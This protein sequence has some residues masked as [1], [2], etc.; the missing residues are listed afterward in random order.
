MATPEEIK[1]IA[2]LYVAYF[3]RAPDPEGLEFWVNQLDNGRDFATISQD[4]ADSP[5]AKE[6]YPFLATPEVSGLDPT[7]LVT[8]IYNN[9]FG[10]DPEAQ[11]LN[12]W[13]DVVNSGAVAVGD[14]VEAI[15]LGAQDAVVE[16]ELVLDKTTVENRI[17]CALEYSTA[18][19]LIPG[20]EFDTAA[21]NVAR[22]VVDSVD[23]TQESVDA[24]KLVLAEYIAGEGTQSGATFTLCEHE[25]LVS[26]EVINEQ[27]VTETVIYWGFNPHSNGETD[28]DNTAEPNTN[29]LTNEGPSDGGI[30]A[31][32]FFND[33]FQ[34]IVAANFNEIDEIDVDEDTFSTIDFASLRDVTVTNGDAGT[35]TV[36]FH[37]SD[38]SADDI[39]LGNA[40]LDL[41]RDLIFDEE[42]NSRFFEQE[43]AAQVP[44]YVTLS[45]AVTLDGNIP[46]TTQIGTVDAV[47]TTVEGAVYATI[48]PI[49]T[50][51]V[52]NGGTFEPGF[53]DQDGQIDNLIVAG[54]LDLLH[55]AIIDGG[56]G[57]NTLE[58]DAKGHFAQPKSL[59]NIQQISIEN[60]PNI[61]TQNDAD[62]S[63][64][65]P[66]VQEGAIGDPDSVIDLTRAR[67]VE[68]VTIT[69]GSYDG[70]DVGNV[71]GEDESSQ[72]GDLSVI[73]LRND[74]TLTLQ[75]Q[76]QNGDVL[77][78]TSEG[79]TGD[80]FTVILDNV[81]AETNMYIAE[82]GTTLNLVS[83]GGGNH[84]D[85]LTDLNEGNL[86][87]LNISG[88]AHLFIENNLNAV[89]DD[90]TPATIDA[91]ANTGGVDLEI[92][93][94]EQLTFIGSAGDDRFAVGT[95]QGG[96]DL[97]IDY[98]GDME[99]TITNA[100][101][102]NY[103][104]IR[105][106]DV[107][108]TDG[109]GD[110]S[111]DSSNGVTAT[112]TAGDGDNTVQMDAGH[113][114]I[115]FGDGD[116]TLNLALVDA[117][118]LNPVG[119]DEVETGADI[120]LGDGANYVAI[121]VS[122][123]S[124]TNG[125][126]S[127]TSV[128]LDMPE[129]SI[130]AGDG[131]NTILIPGLP[132]DSGGALT[133][134]DITTGGGDDTILVAAAEANISTGGGDD[135][136]TL[137]GVDDDYVTEV[138]SVVSGGEDLS[139]YNFKGFIPSVYGIEFT[140]DTG[141][142]SATINLGAF[143]DNLAEVTGAMVAGEGSSITGNDIT[144]FV[145]TDAD[146]RAATL[147][148]I[149]AIVM[150]DDNRAFAGQGYGDTAGSASGAASLTLL[151]TQVAQLLAEG[152]DFSTQGETFGAKSVLTIVITGDVTLSDLID[153]AS[154]NDSVKLCFVVEDGASLTLTAQE[155]HTYVAP[156]GI[157]VDDQ[158]GFVDNQVIVTDAGPEFN[159]FDGTQNGGIG[160]G[161]IAGDGPMEDVLIL[162][163]EEGF[164]RPSQ[165]PGSSL[166]QWNSDEDDN[167]DVTVY[168]FATDLE[169]TGSAD[170]SVN[171]PIILGDAFT[172]DF[173]EFTGDF[174]QTVNG[175]PT[176]TV[177]NFQAITPDVN[178][179]D[180]DP[181]DGDTE[182]TGLPDPDTWG[183][184]AGNGTSADPVRINMLVEEGTSTGDCDLGVTEGGFISSGV[185]Q[186]VLTGFHT[187][188][189]ELLSQSG[190]HS[191][192]IVVCDQTE[193]L[194]V[195]G[196]QNNRNS[197]VTFWQVN[198][199]TEILM[200][201]DGYANSSDQEKNL[202]DP[203]LSEVG[204]VTANFFEPGA[205][206]VVRVTNQGTELGLNED[207]EDGFDPDGERKLDVAGVVLNNADRLLLAVEDGDAVIHD[208]TGHDLERI[209]VTGPEDVEIVVAGI[210]AQDSNDGSKDDFEGMMEG[211][212]SDNLVSLDASGVAGIF[213]LTLTSDA[214]LSGVNLSGVDV[215]CLDLDSAG[216]LTMTAD[217]VVEYG[218]SLISKD[219]LVTLDIVDMGDQAIDMA[220]L[221]S[222]ELEIGTVTFVD[223]AVTVNAATNFGG[224][225][226]LIIPE[227]SEVTM[228]VAQFETA[229]NGDGSSP[230]VEDG[231]GTGNADDNKLILTDV[232]NGEALGADPVVEVDLSAVADD[233]DV[234]I[235]FTDFTANENFDVSTAGGETTT[236]V[237]N[238]TTDLSA[239]ELGTV[240]CIVLQDGA[241]LTLSQEQI[242][243]LIDAVPT[244]DISDVIKLAP[245]A[246]AT[247]NINEI[248]GT[249]T[250]LDLNELVDDWAGGLDIGI[251]TIANTD[252]VVELTD[253]TTGG[254]DE[255][256]TPTAD[257][258]S[259]EFGI[260][261]TS[262]IL[263]MAQ[264]LD[265]DGIGFISGD[266]EV[267]LIDVANNADGDDADLEP[268]N[269]VIDTS[270][271]T[272][273]KG[274]LSLLELGAAITDSGESVTLNETSDVS[275]FEIILTDGQLFGFAT[276]AQASG[277]TVTEDV[278]VATNPTGIVWLFDTWSGTPID[279][280]NYDAD[281][282]TLF[283]D[284][285]LVNGQNEEDIWTTLA[286]SIV[287]Q[288]YN[289][290]APKGLVVFSRTN[291]FEPF[292]SA[293][294]GITFDDQNEFQTTGE[295]ILNLEGNVTIGDITIADTVGGGAFEG[296]T[297]SS[298]YDVENSPA[299]DNVIIQPN[300][301][302]D[303]FFNAPVAANTILNL[304]IDARDGQIDVPFAN[305]VDAEGTDGDLDD[306]L[307]LI[308]GTVYLGTPASGV[309]IAVI[310]I[311]SDHSVLI[312]GIDY[313]DP[314]L[315]Q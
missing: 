22:A 223:E 163:T 237:I 162:I 246:T 98:N 42:G 80:G 198:W 281:I 240:D 288:K 313:S 152:V 285:D 20:F 128:F 225:D 27:L 109:D 144:L 24:A 256:V 184:I 39:S 247:L 235:V 303:I 222:D 99:V 58:V 84:I 28:V 59:V 248:D 298:T 37:Y 44:V 158:N 261:S 143:A 301:V 8:S 260:E 69:E 82:N 134:V 137:L 73:G 241:T 93:G 305:G 311:A 29:N 259:P 216:T 180:N 129:V 271:I 4:F 284:E 315:T 312:G 95:T 120:N 239:G 160:G 238:G 178:D 106:R 174:E 251:L 90:D 252:S 32:A 306:G 33:Y 18:T 100:S 146:L 258:I 262:L 206:A 275:G 48:P 55:T 47:L 287:V 26:P 172:I 278:V 188:E 61:Y 277:A 290:E 117:R 234:D 1:A 177:A 280:V 282:D 213:T 201:G 3:D 150:D 147:D 255:I 250:P 139:D 154:W 266:A 191:A 111:V 51:S 85:Q 153:F 114:T 194:E 168:P 125:S 65:Y 228:T 81:N 105:T 272:A 68:N 52:N 214:D 187:D 46:N 78:R 38:G 204:K 273:P 181:N 289:D 208:V 157:A 41:L 123:S 86:T 136:I 268:D 88:D 159:A 296:M 116:N 6:I 263:T 283:V 175:V 253:W 205:N 124:A 189:F 257:L 196:L 83:Q 108:I 79:F 279:T 12:F 126:G 161:S 224:A 2:G 40:Y 104:Q 309:N 45:G 190:A 71:G 167:I 138:A 195:L 185:Q 297:I 232:P 236:A 170:L 122:E 101:G 209:I 314:D 221:V 151:D 87:T 202:G 199:G 243:D 70:L 110:I 171:G 63:S 307:P 60:L 43:V 21:Y 115:T 302:G 133:H 269:L 219:G 94:P 245:G 155:L 16:G 176:L 35:G 249:G 231:D 292:G 113:A 64:D 107:T 19:S 132:R 49:L 304:L 25:V 286:S 10:R 226:L 127:S 229:D 145:N 218:A 67:D 50:P 96:S 193:D 13:V 102:D 7:N 62:N 23:A 89:F 11:G 244:T 121:D 254:A 149:T 300:I 17:E 31:D 15:M 5:E 92:A 130:T 186:F 192:D 9:L 212:N 164:N 220:S 140:V 183:F 179:P 166:I 66:D 103:Y 141:A 215:I 169:I 294:D 54:Q 77:V 14:M 200:E 227:D 230:V 197:D 135:E 36:T 156:E 291:T 97:G 57:Y 274:T 233:V 148:G 265:L 112:I 173:S 293:L 295:I 299:D 182:I 165:D 131:G 217:Q 276:E 270:G 72:P 242:Q 76:F 267:S 264:F 203:D 119:L 211:L 56:Q 75:G 74:A 30:P 210:A 142:G 34:T 53:P 207:A 91:S 118:D 308:T 310:D